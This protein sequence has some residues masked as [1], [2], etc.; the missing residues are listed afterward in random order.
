MSSK[1]CALIYL[2]VQNVS[3]SSTISGWLCSLN[4][5][6]A[7]GCS[8]NSR[9]ATS[10]A[11]WQMILLDDITVNINGPKVS[12]VE[13]WRVNSLSNGVGR[14][15]RN[16]RMLRAMFMTSLLRMAAESH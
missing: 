9:S 12:I 15:P 11:V 10:V 3:R 16:L 13:D 4:T 1:I 2:R 8:A 14:A 7:S 6:T 5:L